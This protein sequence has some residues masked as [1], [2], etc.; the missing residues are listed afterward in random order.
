MSPAYIRTAFLKDK[1]T[2]EIMRPESVGI[3]RSTLVLGKHSGRHA[4]REGSP[5]L[6][7]T[8]EGTTLI[9]PSRGSSRL[10]TGKRGL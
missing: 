5:N 3:S 1:T 2:Y 10:P 7:T 9:R 6:A 4:F 8:Y